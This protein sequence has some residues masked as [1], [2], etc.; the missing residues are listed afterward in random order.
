MTIADLYTDFMTHY[1]DLRLKETTAA[2]YRTNFER[3]ILP[4]IADL[5]LELLDLS[6]LDALV[7]DL[8]AKDLSRRS[9]VY[10]LATLSKSYSYAT[11]RGYVSH[12]PLKDYDFPRVPKLEYRLL[13]HEQ[14]DRLLA[15]ADGTD[16]LPALL[17]AAHY[18]LRRGE[19]LG[20]KVEDLRGDLLHLRRTVTY[21]K[22]ERVV[23]SPKS[24]S[25]RTIKLMK[26]DVALFRSY[27]RA[28]VKNADGYLV[29]DDDGKELTTGMLDKRFVRL[30][31]AADLPR[32]RFHD[33]RHSYATIML[34]HGVNPKIVSTV[35]G[36]S[37][38]DITLDLYSHCTPD[39]QQACLNVFERYAALGS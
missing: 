37:S 16:E 22:G 17:L 31:D 25:W 9:I 5:K 39:L 2:G 3:H 34:A 33:L 28:R 29:R 1:V 7:D 11:K 12:N 24:G 13:D 15:I 38:V 20:V 27:D 4:S 26:D 8:K 6:V 21:I 32:C 18:G 35:L 10:V 36:H 30:L 19:C 14:L 23:S